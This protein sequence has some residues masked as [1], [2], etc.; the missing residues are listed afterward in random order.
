MLFHSYLMHMLW[1]QEVNY[2]VGIRG[3]L[4]QEERVFPEA[5][6]FE[7]V[8][9]QTISGVGWGLSVV[10]CARWC[11]RISL[12]GMCAI[13][14]IIEAENLQSSFQWD[15]STFDYAVLSSY[16]PVGFQMPPI[17]V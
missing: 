10:Q 11:A 2:I 3:L 12:Q 15:K 1:M 6:S 5:E 17:A 4:A 9:W 14:S 8:A 16:Q 7:H 13:S